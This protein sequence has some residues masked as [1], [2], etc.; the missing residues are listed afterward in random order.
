M[1]LCKPIAMAALV[2]TCGAGAA[3]ADPWKDESGNR[4]DAYH[5]H[6]DYDWP[7]YRGRIP[8]GHL[9]PPGSCRVWYF[10][11]P[12]G[13]QPS[14]TGCRRAERLADRTGGYVVDDLGRIY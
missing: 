3:A 1:G 9:P 10:E 12:P 11:R 5:E 8:E 6:R 7:N 2:L 4:R 14:P 13:Q